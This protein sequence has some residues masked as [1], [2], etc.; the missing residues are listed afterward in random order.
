VPV[1]EAD[2][3]A[4]LP[5]DDVPLVVWLPVFWPVERVPLEAGDLPVEVPEAA[6]ELPAEPVAPVVLVQ[7]DPVTL[8]VYFQ[9]PKPFPVTERPPI[10]RL[11]PGMQAGAL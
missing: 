10:V 6:V 5:P 4:P 11:F 1:P 7:A 3:F 8:N 9:V 2:P